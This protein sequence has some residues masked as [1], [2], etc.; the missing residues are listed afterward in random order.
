MQDGICSSKAV[1]ASKTR[2]HS[3]AMTE[4]RRRAQA[5]TGVCVINGMCMHLGL[6]Y[7]FSV[8][9][10]AIFFSQ[11]NPGIF[12]KRSAFKVAYNIF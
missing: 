7:L 1:T 2:L 9:N 11:D 4:V 10:T 5:I 8:K 6:L 12:S 3:S